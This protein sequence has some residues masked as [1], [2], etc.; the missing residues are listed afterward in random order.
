MSPQEAPA[1]LDVLTSWQKRGLDFSQLV[2]R[3]QV[4]QCSHT[5]VFFC[6]YAADL[7]LHFNSSCYIC[8]CQY[9]SLGWL[10]RKTHAWVSANLSRTSTEYDFRD[11]FEQNLHNIHPLY[12][13]SQDF[14]FTRLCVSSS[15]C[16][17]FDSLYNYLPTK[18]ICN[19]LAKSMLNLSTC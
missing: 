15:V 3:D 5:Q 10:T 11:V 16:L 9:S 6:C 18:Y 7:H 17:P 12:L 1:L 4:S 19:L 2:K 8:L 14:I 13:G